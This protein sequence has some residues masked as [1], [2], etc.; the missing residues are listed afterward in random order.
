MK[1]R[2]S[3]FLAVI[4]LSAV[5]LFAPPN[6]NLAT[7]QIS[8]QLDSN[9]LTGEFGRA[10]R[11]LIANGYT[12]IQV[13]GQGFTKFQVEA[14]HS[15]TRYWFK[16]D[17]LG[18][19]NER[20]KIGV[21]RSTLPLNKISA[22]LASRG[23]SRINVEDH[24]GSYLAVACLGSDR[25]RVRVNYHGQ[26]EKQRRLGTCRKSLTPSDVEVRLNREGYTRIKF[27]SR[28]LPTYV[29][30]A[31][32]G[33]RKF[34]LKINKFAETISQKRLGQCRGPINPNKL[35][36]IMEKRGFERVVVIDNQLPRYIVEVC[37][38]KAERLEITLNRYG[39]IIERHKTGKCSRDIDKNKFA[40]LLR[41]QGYTHNQFKNVGNR[42]IEV[43]SCYKGRQ[44]HL[45]FN[46]YGEYLSERELGE[47]PSWTFKQLQS[48]LKNQKHTRIRFFA[49]ACIKGKHVRYNVNR[50]GD[51]SN[52]KTLGRC[53]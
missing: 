19:T 26:I 47:C 51:R 16:S 38:K 11:N 34:A 8:L 49:E 44:F 35:V 32:L 4:M 50:F 40:V 53:K 3:S 1:H 9:L 46:R 33:K 23:Y 30:E 42:R 22:M 6:V 48:I 15:G 18:R 36:A 37:G 27:K 2:S 39:D 12:Q 29:V 21:C 45:V 28:K 7:G 43:D 41:K 31:C 20:R 10:K 5:G 17:S 14:C 24:G 13:V 52:R 25:V